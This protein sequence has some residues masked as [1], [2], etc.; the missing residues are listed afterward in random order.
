[1]KIEDSWNDS[2]VLTELGE[3]LSQKRISLSLTQ[4][5]LAERAGVAKKTIERIENGGAVQ[6]TSIIHV[7]REL[8]LLSALDNVV[9]EVN[10]RPMDLLKLKGKVRRR[11]SKSHRKKNHESNWQWGE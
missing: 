5:E 4:A 2:A 7:L 9:P 11:A 6:F 10:T 1:M 3:R 8:K